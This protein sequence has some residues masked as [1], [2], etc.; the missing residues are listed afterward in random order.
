[1]FNRRMDRILLPLDL[2]SLTFG[3]TW[4]ENASDPTLPTNMELKDDL[5]HITKHTYA[6]RIFVGLRSIC[7]VSPWA[8]RPTHAIPGQR[9]V[10]DPMRPTFIGQENDDLHGSCVKNIEEPLTWQVSF[11]ENLDRVR[12]PSSLQHLQLGLSR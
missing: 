2:K 7:L 11:H 1:M 5:E 8:K 9:N 4:E 10:C 3:V 6:H 12:F